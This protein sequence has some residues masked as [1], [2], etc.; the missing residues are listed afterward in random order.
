MANLSSPSSPRPREDEPRIQP[1]ANGISFQAGSPGAEWLASMTPSKTIK[2]PAV[3]GRMPKAAPP[4]GVG[5]PPPCQKNL[6]GSED[7]EPFEPPPAAPSP[8]QIQFSLIQTMTEDLER[9]RALMDQRFEDLQA[10]EDILQITISE[11]IQLALDQYIKNNPVI[12]V[13]DDNSSDPL[14]KVPEVARDTGIQSVHPT[15]IAIQKIC[16]F[17]DILD[18]LI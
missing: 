11:G 1:E 5:V 7:E 15:Q 3:P 17:S 13:N 6:F 8:A 16:G 12:T 10:R 4:H 2:A 14:V 9:S 18:R